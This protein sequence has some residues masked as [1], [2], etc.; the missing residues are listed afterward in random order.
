[1]SSLEKYKKWNGKPRLSRGQCRHTLSKTLVG[2]PSVSLAGA[3]IGGSCH[4]YHFC[5]DKHVFFATN[6]WQIFVATKYFCQDRR[7]TFVATKM[8][9]VP[10]PANDNLG[11]AVIK[12]NDRAERL[13][14]K[15]AVT[16]GLHLGR[17]EVLRNLGNYLRAQSKG[18]HTERKCSKLLFFWNDEKGPSPIKPTL[19]YFDCNP[20]DISERGGSACGFSCARRYYLQ[21]SLMFNAVLTAMGILMRN[22][23]HESTSKSLIQ[24]SSQTT[25]CIWRHSWEEEKKEKKT[26]MKSSHSTTKSMD[27]FSV[28]SC[29]IKTKIW[30]NC[31]LSVVL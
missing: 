25:R 5:R 9:L 24:S 4:K 28:F 29:C 7:R 19:E 13:E 23:G 27:I 26:F 16:C 8:I 10:A 15:E 11:H 3:V 30:N 12:P 31:C 18:C 14:R 6:T 17:S 20:G 2:V 1:M 22:T 21:L